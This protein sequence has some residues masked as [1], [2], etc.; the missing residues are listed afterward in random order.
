[1][2][3]S[4]AY[5]KSDVLRAQPGIRH[6]YFTRLNGVSSGIYAGRNTGLGS[7]DDRANIL[8]NRSR[9]AADL[10]VTI[11][12]LATPYQ[13]HSASAFVVDIVWPQGTGP[14]ADAVV[15]K[16][17]GFMIG[18]GTA[19]CGSVLFADTKAGVIAAAHAGWR[20][21]AGGVLENTLTAME[22]LGAD[23]ADI[24]AVLGP[25]IA[26]KSYEVGAEFA[27]RLKNL[28]EDNERYFIPG[29]KAGHA[30]FDLPAYIKNRLQS[31]GVGHADDLALDT[32][33]DETRFYSY[34]RTTHRGEADYG[35]LL[36]AIILEG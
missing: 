28:S 22:N 2:V 25:T 27:E 31:A 30:M 20:G 36:S 19:D 14:K 9:C 1:M 21:A 24:T 29:K 15:T 33:D 34:R 4:E 13:T 26:Q 35:R 32:Y 16:R 11:D 12:Q 18:I 6:A 5:I 10:G 7:S 23:R 8:E 3:S 17:P